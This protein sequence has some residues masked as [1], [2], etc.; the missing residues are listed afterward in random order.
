MKAA[1]AESM[2]FA[3]LVRDTSIA[4]R[5]RSAAIVDKRSSQK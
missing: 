2:S 3:L 5:K 1:A 4:R